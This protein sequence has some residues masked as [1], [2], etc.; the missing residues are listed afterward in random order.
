MKI[1]T[2]DQIRDL[3]RRAM[4]EGAIPGVVL[5]ENAGR[6]VFTF[7]VEHYGSLHGKSVEVACG[8]GNN[9]GDG[10]V[11]ARYLHLMGADVTLT[12]CG[13]PDKIRGDARTHYAILS[14]LGIRP[15]EPPGAP[16]LIFDALL[17]TGFTGMPREEMAQAIQR[18][19]ARGCPVIAVDIPSGVHADTGETPG[20]AVRA[21]QTVTFAYPKRGMFLPPGADLVG[22]LIVR[23]IGF[24]WESLKPETEDRWLRPETLRCLLPRRPREGHKGDFGHLLIVGGSWGMSGAPTMTAR[25]ALRAGAALVTVAVPQSVLPMVA[26]RLDEAMTVGVPEASGVFGAQS[27]ERVQEAAEK[28]DALCIGIGAGQQPDTQAFLLRLAREVEKPLVLDADALNALALHPKALFGRTLPTILTPHPGECARLLNRSTAAVQADRRSAVVGAAE[29]FGA[30]VVLKGARTL[31]ASP[32][33][34]ALEAAGEES[35][36]VAYNTSGNPGMATGGSGDTLTGILGALLVQRYAPISAFDAACLGVY[37]HGAA[38]DLAAQT[39]QIGRVAGDI[40]EHLP[41]AI[42]NLQRPNVSE[43]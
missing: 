19:N 34:P 28:C 24:D 33:D 37:L 2:T 3:D 29:K 6:A 20:D 32:P 13:D 8:T 38:G 35:R 43:D 22:E 16:D 18:I 5:M 31:V 42:L 26:A 10:F 30:V 11:I 9:G 25:A 17:G 4:I 41:Q 40:A 23:D 21:A 39:G 36:F 7:A 1:V 27:F 15:Q 14:N 12:V